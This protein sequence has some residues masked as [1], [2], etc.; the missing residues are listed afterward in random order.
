MTKFTEEEILE[1]IGSYIKGYIEIPH[2]DKTEFDVDDILNKGIVDCTIIKR[3]YEE[4]IPNTYFCKVEYTIELKFQN[5]EEIIEFDII[6]ENYY[7]DNLVLKN[8]LLTFENINNREFLGKIRGSFS[9]K[10]DKINKSYLVDV[11]KNKEII[12]NGSITINKIEIK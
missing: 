7:T 9:E 6:F 12:T 11:L 4:R 3:K 2:K 10:I 8:R 5:F 1:R